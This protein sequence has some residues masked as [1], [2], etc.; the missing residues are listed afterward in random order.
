MENA[1]Q[2]GMC[3]PGEIC[4]GT[5]LTCACMSEGRML[6]S[7]RPFCKVFT[8]KMNLSR[9]TDRTFIGRVLRLPLRLIPPQTVF[10]VLQGPLRGMKWVTGSGVHGY[11]LGIY[12]NEKQQKFI[13][14]VKKGGVVYDI[15]ANVGFYTLLSSVLVGE[16]GQ[17]VA[18]EPLPAN[19]V[20]LERH[21]AMNRIRNVQVV[22][23]A[24]SD[25]NGTAM[26]SD[27]TERSSGHLDHAGK[28]EVRTITL[29]TLYERGEIPPPDI[30]KIDVEGG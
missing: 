1:P 6:G 23:A 26:F 21:L 29:D 22:Q 30:M 27:R 24:V 20:Y 15:G 8:G 13:Q 5:V 14:H 25:E 28:L 7:A 4:R 17:V 19:I 11:W 12:E 3:T 9:I 2:A 18:F 10:P 16:T